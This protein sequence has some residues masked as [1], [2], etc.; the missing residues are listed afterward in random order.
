M[1]QRRLQQIHP[2]NY[3][4]LTSLVCYLIREVTS[5]QLIPPAHVRESLNILQTQTVMNSFGTLFLHTLDIRDKFVIPDIQEY[6]DGIVLKSLGIAKTSQQRSTRTVNTTPNL[7]SIEFPI[8]PTPAWS[9]IKDAVSSNPASFVRPFTYSRYLGINEHAVRLFLTFS[10]MMRLL[11][12]SS[13]RNP[14]AERKLETLEEAM[15][16]EWEYEC[17]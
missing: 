15:A 6:D 8:G 10:E 14:R 13:W 9:E 5:T 7:P 1:L 16:R 17:W 4:V 2:P 11:V 3:G 12:A